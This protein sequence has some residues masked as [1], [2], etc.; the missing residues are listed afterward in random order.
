MQVTF[1][2]A[3]VLGLIFGGALCGA[4]TGSSTAAEKYLL[5][6][7]FQPGE[8]L[9]W[10]VA[11]RSQI[12]TT[13]AGTTQTAETTTTSV[14]AW[15]VR[16]VRAD[17]AAVFE[18]MVESVDMR[19]RLSGRDEVHYNS[20]SKEPQPGGFEHVAK[21]VGVPLSVITLSPT[22]KILHRTQNP[23][24]AAAGNEGEITIPL[25]EQPVAVG[26]QWTSP[27]EIEATQP[28]GSIRRVKALQ[29]YTLLGV[30]TGVASIRVVTQILTPIHDPAI[31]AQLVQFETSGTVRFD[32]DAG[33][34]ISQQLDVDKGVVGFRGEASSIRYVTR[35]TEEFLSAEE[36]LAARAK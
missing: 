27:N 32:I 26:Q 21:A 30:K 33:R 31:E 14:K 2:R 36:K 19:H 18:H 20:Q 1:L 17:G 4:E 23:V 6:Y 15:R 7:K 35:F 25:S 12:R 29:T 8:T 9:R 3:A 5:R 28:G 16:E 22:G 24:K 10:N 34:I 13:I 11:H